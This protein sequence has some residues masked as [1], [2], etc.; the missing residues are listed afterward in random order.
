MSYVGR[1]LWLFFSPLVIGPI[2]LHW[3]AFFCCVQGNNRNWSPWYLPLKRAYPFHCQAASVWEENRSESLQSVV[4]LSVSLAGS[5]CGEI[6]FKCFEGRIGT[7]PSACL[8]IWT[9]VRL[10]RPLCALHL[11][12][13][14]P[15]LGVTG[16]FCLLWHQFLCVIFKNWKLFKCPARMVYVSYGKTNTVL[17][18]TDL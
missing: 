14:L 5:S 10:Q 15:V 16:E 4:E 7:L 9:S 2:F 6:Q 11:S 8:G 13:Q 3:L 12:V 1:F 18:C 17:I